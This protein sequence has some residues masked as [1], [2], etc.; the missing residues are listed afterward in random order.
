MFEK[1]PGNLNLGLFCEI[2]LIFLSNSS[3][4]LQQNKG[5]FSTLVLTTY[6]RLHTTFLP[7]F[8]LFSRKGRNYCAQMQGYQ[9]SL[10]NPQLGGLKNKLSIVG[11]ISVKLEN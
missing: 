3:I 9:K 7:L 5:I 6:H 11:T 2:L 8:F 10:N 1:I 4:K